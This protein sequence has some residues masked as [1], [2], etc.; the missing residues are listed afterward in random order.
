LEAAIRR[1]LAY[2][3][4]ARWQTATAWAA[5]LAQ[6][7]ER[8][9]PPPDRR[10]EVVGERLLRLLADVERAD[11]TSELGSLATELG[12]SLRQP[13][14]LG[15]VATA[16]GAALVEGVDLEGIELPET[17]VVQ[18][19]DMAGL[20][21]VYLDALVV[22]AASLDDFQLDEVSHATVAGGLVPELQL[23]VATPAA[24]AEGM[25]AASG[26]RMPSV[27][28]PR[29]ATTG[30]VVAVLKATA[31]DVRVRL[32]DL[33]TREALRRLE[34]STEAGEVDHGQLAEWRDEMETIRLGSGDFEEIALLER[35]RSNRLVV[36]PE[37]S[38]EAER[39]LGVPDPCIRVGLPLGSAPETVADAARREAT[40]WR[41]IAGDISRTRDVR[42]AASVVARV[43]ERT[44]GRQHPI[45]RS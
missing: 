10:E 24:K 27:L 32:V 11:P 42:Y 12:R 36:D 16:A 20:S 33:R 31:D 22:I 28:L 13:L 35:L 44:E 14:T 41:A 19:E 8:K 5:A 34:R 45:K 18:L 17:N 38:S 43:F 39:I 26:S 23:V 29:T 25:Q 6:G 37:I 4:D 9:V 3:P 30:D 1:G 15:L 7:V 21:S 40:R 2:E